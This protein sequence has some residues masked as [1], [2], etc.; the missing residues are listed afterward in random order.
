MPTV[1]EI[2]TMCKAGN[3]TEAYNAAK[4][5]LADSPQNVWAQRGI[6]WALYYMLKTD[7]DGQKRLD[8]FTHMEELAGLDMLTIEADSLIFDNVLWKV[9]DFVK[10]TPK[11]NIPE[12]ERLFF[13][14][15]KYT[16]TP[17]KGYSYLLRTYLDFK[18]WNHLTDFLEWWNLDNLLPEDYQQFK[19]E[20]GKKAMSLA[21]RSY[22]AYAK[23][24]LGLNDQNKIHEFLPKLEKLMEDYPEMMYPGYFC[25]KLKLAINTE[26]EEALNS[27][28][29]FVR[30]K[31]SEFW[32]W[33]LLSE[34]YKNEPEIHQACLLRAVHCKT[35]EAFL[36]NVRKAL[37]ATY[38]SQRDYPRAK[39]Q[40]DQIIRCFMQ[41]G[42]RLPYE[43]QNW[44]TESWIQN[45]TADSSDGMEYKKTT[46]TILSHGANESIAAVTYVDA[47][48]KQAILVYGEKKS[49]RVKFS[50]LRI[51]IK[52]GEIL[53]LHWIPKKDERIN[54][55]NAELLDWTALKDNAYIKTIDG[56]IEK[57]ANKPF[58][59]LKGQEMNCFI[60]PNVVQQ[61]NLN[62]EENVSALAVYTYNKKKEEWNWSC[63]SLK[64]K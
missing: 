62:G 23:A 19:L 58:A 48:N 47:T 40:L 6:G 46:D 28:M 17:S 60:T 24:I 50:D 49:V 64:K 13:L 38:L 27:V 21:E 8:F 63:V 20:S 39:Y 1:K 10:H 14:V 32:V 22:I 57:P 16:F 41:E 25:A 9:A 29:P 7:I 31:Q 4:A 34:I 54:I 36:V 55:V 35:Q 43:I 12:I 61:Y 30:K 3:I 18:G 33:Q 37:I 5:D 44:T 52:E 51:Q 11:E 59:F 45:T 2:T 42:W 56:S 15:S 53:K 26:K